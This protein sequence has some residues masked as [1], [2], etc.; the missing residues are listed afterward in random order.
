MTLLDA[1]IQAAPPGKHEYHLDFSQIR[2]IAS[3]S[4]SSVLNFTPM[5]IRSED[6][7]KSKTE[8]NNTG[9]IRATIGVNPNLRVDGTHGYTSGEERTQKR[10]EVVGHYFPSDRNTIT[11]APQT[12]TMWKYT[13]NSAFYPREARNMFE[14]RP[15]ATFGL[16][17]TSSTVPCFEV[18][19][20]TNYSW[21]TPSQTFRN[22]FTTS[23]KPKNQ[24]PAFLNFLHQTSVVIDLDKVNGSTEWVV[25]LTADER[26][27]IAE[28]GKEAGTTVRQLERSGGPSDCF[29]SLKAALHG[30]I[31]LNDEQRKSKFKLQ[32]SSNS[33]TNCC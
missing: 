9:G 16:S 27:N 2:F 24:P 22:W 12:T 28:L 5:V 6:D 13:H 3:S 10:W 30:R 23:S 11:G 18:E 14:P 29:V 7:V 17:Q 4:P 31:S 21:S 19:V 33:L 25:G 1:E 20:V 8:R 32:V 15:A 26:Q